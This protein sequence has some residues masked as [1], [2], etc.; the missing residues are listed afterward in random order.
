MKKGY[1][2]L[3]CIVLGWLCYGCTATLQ[4]TMEGFQRMLTPTVE[5]Y[6]QKALDHERQGK[7]REARL[8]WQVV[9][10]LDPQ[11]ASIGE[12]IKT[13][14]RGIA[15]AVQNHYDSAVASFGRG[16]LASAQRELLIVLRL[17]PHHKSAREYL[18]RCLNHDEPRLYKVI[19]GD[20][21]IKIA[22]RTYNDP[23]KAYIVAYY[24]D[25][26]PDK[27]L[28]VGTVLTLP[29]L[30]PQYMVPRADINAMVFK[31]QNALNNKAYDH[32]AALAVKILEKVPGHPEAPDIKD[33]AHFGK[34][35][36]MIRDR[37]YLAAL[38]ELKKVSPNFKGRDAAIDEARNHI[39]QQAVA[40]KLTLAKSLMQQK[41][42]LGTIN[43]TEEILAQ[44]PNN[45]I[46]RYLFNAAN[47]ERAK[48]LIE[49]QKDD[50][51]IQHLQAIQQPFEDTD[52][53]IT[54]ARGR[55]HARA[56]VF[57]RKGVKHFLNEELEL[58][59]K[60]WQQSLALNP[61]HP[62]A[63]QDIQ[64]ATELLEKWRGLEKE[65]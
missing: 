49:D 39:Q 54:Q 23:T 16:D 59:I 40:E 33:Q 7:L 13:L 11:N 12:I 58:A 38:G 55:L 65:Q 47:Y 41:A 3:V 46:A 32:A 18:D 31:A 52:Q 17:D 42:Y 4:S 29:T 48:E 26:D 6:R 34:A 8:A 25:L 5:I 50:I 36:A 1:L 9:A 64:N 2:W 43:V 61:K 24:N 63:A 45:S 60:A 56:E 15:N 27:P 10:R 35:K 62:K 37:K 19:K 44:E 53:L 22:T 30:D 14:D 51:A 20:S 57:Y 21:F 28:L